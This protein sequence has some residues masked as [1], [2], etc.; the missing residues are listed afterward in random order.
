MRPY[1][2]FSEFYQFIGR[3]IRVLHAPG[4]RRPRRPGRAVP[5]HRLPRR[6]RARR[7]HRHHL[8]RERHGPA[9]RARHARRLERAAGDRGRAAG[10]DGPRDAPSTRRPSCCSSAA[11]SNS[12]SSTTTHASNSARVEREREALAQRYAAYAAGHRQPGHLRAVRR[13][14]GPARV[15]SDPTT[16]G[17]GLP[18][19]PDCASASNSNAP[20]IAAASSPSWTPSSRTHCAARCR[21]ARAAAW[22]PTRR[23]GRRATRTGRRC[24]AKDRGHV[25]RGRDGEPRRLGAARARNSARRR[26]QLRLVGPPGTTSC[27]QPR[28]RRTPQGHAPRQPHGN[29]RV[30]G[31]GAGLRAASIPHDLRSAQAGKA[32][33]DSQNKDWPSSPRCSPP[34]V[35]TWITSSRSS[36]PA[37]AGRDYPRTS[38]RPPE[39]S[40]WKPGRATRH[41][42]WQR[43]C[44]CG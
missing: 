35:L 28:R 41:P 2:S 18:R 4:A 5:R 29:V 27:L 19:S 14:H 11:P 16:Y 21:R 39:P 22:P 37:A 36:G 43:C 1:G 8:R 25:R 30:V 9:H 12:A 44:G 20:K 26:R 38:A 31:A 32:D 15:V 17:A 42:K 24:R 33:V 34:P 40:S 23:R 3:G 13:D 6:A 7:A 10:R